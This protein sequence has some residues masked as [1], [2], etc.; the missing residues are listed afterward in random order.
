MRLKS[1]IMVKLL[2]S[3][4]FIIA[5]LTTLK[6]QNFHNLD[7]MQKCD[8]SRTGL[9]YWDL[10]WGKEKSV[11]P[12]ILDN[13]NAVAISGQKE[14]S[15][16][17]VE[18]EA[19]INDMSEV[20]ILSISSLIKCSE[21]I[22]KGA[23][24]NIGLYDR[25]GALIASKDMGGFY[26]IDWFKG[27]NDWKK[28]TISI[29]CPKE[30]KKI[31]IGMILF[32][33][34]TVWFSD[35]AVKTTLIIDRKPNKLSQKYINAACEIIAKNSLVRDSIN[36][37]S[38]KETAL[39]IAG[40]AKKYSDCFLA[41]NFLLESLRSYGDLHSF[42]MSEK[43]VSNWKNQGSQVSKIEFPE[44]KLV[45]SCGYISVP[46]FHG[47]NS[48]LMTAYTDSL[49]KGIKI[50]SNAKIKGWIV[51]LRK[52]TGGNMEP[53]IAGLGPLFSAEKLGSLID[54]NGKSNSWYYKN[55][56]YYSDE[57]KGWSVS[58]PF[59]LTSILPIAVL[60]SNQ[61]GS[62]GE[63]VT[64]SFI[65]NSDTKS[66]GEP[67]W[68]LTTGNGSFELKDGSQIFLASTIMADRDGKQ[69]VSSIIPD[70]SIKD[71]TNNDEIMDAAIKWI[72]E[73]K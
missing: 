59:L 57:Y 68:G 13:K 28:H 30:T 25:N 73:P 71:T 20:Q 40:S 44:C 14:N 21:V 34:G 39:K 15:V 1:K 61:T 3:I 48:K 33:K 50:L 64:I 23:G 32:G 60:T 22:G 18:Q 4:V 69:Y 12:A 31:K 42:F 8:T 24:L 56:K 27:T 19:Y 53:M 11:S 7:F 55:G 45:D 5:S 65:G 72:F 29:V 54:V 17:F 67:T 38:L 2:S 6:G 37:N 9:C 49:Q 41:I 47:G 70:F 62:S 58:K 26:S 63:I 43:E 35:F 46:P 52:N 10:S 66:F 36:I 16:V 51:D